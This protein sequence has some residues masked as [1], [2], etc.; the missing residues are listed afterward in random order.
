MHSIAE[1]EDFRPVAADAPHLCAWRAAAP[2]RW[3]RTFGAL[4]AFLSVWEI[5]APENLLGSVLGWLG[6]GANVLWF[7]PC[8][9]R[10][11]A[12]AALLAACVVR[13]EA[14]VIALRSR[15][16]LANRLG[17]HRPE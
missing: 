2:S 10:I 6:V 12:T 4:L 16:I 3:G 14:L 11:L 7:V 17:S 9:V 5:L 8:Y 13:G 1:D 15:R